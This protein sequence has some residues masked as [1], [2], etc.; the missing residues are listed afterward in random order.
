MKNVVSLICL[1]L[2]VGGCT[3]SQQ[4]VIN[5]APSGQDQLVESQTS[6]GTAVPAVPTASDSAESGSTAS[7]GE[8]LS[9]E[10]VTPVDQL[11]K[12]PAEWKGI[13]TE[14]QFYVTREKGTERP[15]ENAYW[16]N[17]K[18][19]LYR[20]VCCGNPLFESKTKYKSGTGW[21]SFYQPVAKQAVKEESDNTLFMTRTE[22]LCNHCD[23]HLGHVFDDGPAPT[24]MRYCMNSASL[25]FVE[26]ADAEPKGEPSLSDQPSSNE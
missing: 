7:S 17:K 22:V 13:L 10:G 23:A 14:E 6:Q 21:P 26:S 12:T 3:D 2:F 19:G 8:N 15:F 11:P 18:D 5:S 9:L 24:G 16:N 1:C 20:C 25:R 4:N